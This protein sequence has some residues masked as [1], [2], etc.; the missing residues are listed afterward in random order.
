MLGAAIACVNCVLLV[1]VLT[2]V[3]RLQKPAPAPRLKRAR[4]TPATKWRMA[5]NQAWQ[6]AFCADPL[7]HACQIDHI[8]PL[9]KGG[10]ND[11]ANLQ[12]LCAN[13]HAAKTIEER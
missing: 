8:M 7:E 10:S 5:A 13:C 11:G 6:C 12:I 1:M 4:P 3:R 9:F 2:L